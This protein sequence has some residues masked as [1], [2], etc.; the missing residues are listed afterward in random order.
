MKCTQI[1]RWLALCGFG[2]VFAMPRALCG[3]EKPRDA[4]AWR[5]SIPAVHARFKGQR[6]TFAHFGDSITETLAFWAPLRE[7]RKNAPP[8]MERAYTRVDAHLRPECWREW[9]GPTY[10]NQGGQTIGWADENVAAWL[11]KRDPEVA[12]V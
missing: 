10:G 12:S 2:L 7:A 11:E 8:E 3:D 4:P 6:G 5:E 9:K 1:A